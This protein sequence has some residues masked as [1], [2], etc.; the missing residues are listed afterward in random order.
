VARWI[1]EGDSPGT[2]V[3]GDLMVDVEPGKEFDAPD[4]WQPEPNPHPLYK[5]VAQ[6]PPAPAKAPQE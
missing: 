3:D 1:Y 4:D 6:K 5:P 2:L